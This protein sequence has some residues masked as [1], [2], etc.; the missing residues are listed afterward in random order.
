VKFIPE[1]DRDFAFTAHNFVSYLKREPQAYKVT[2]EE[3]AE[4]AKAVQTYREALAKLLQARVSCSQSPILTMRKDSARKEAERHVSTLAN[5]IR[6]RPDVSD[7]N[8]KLLRIK[9]RASKLGKRK[10]PKSPPR[11]EFL[12]SGDGV[13]GNIAQGSGSGVHVLRFLD[14]NET[15]AIMA[16][17]D[18]GKV[19]RRKPD[20]AVRVELYFDMVP[21]GDPRGVPNMPYERGWP[22]YLRSFTRSPMEVEFPIPSQPML[23]VYWA[24]WADSTGEVSRWSKPCVARLEGWTSSASALPP[25]EADSAQ[26][27]A[28]KVVFIQPPY[29]L[30]H[31]PRELIDEAPALLEA[32]MKML[33]AA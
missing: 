19:R 2:A 6:A 29:E 16:S 7:S 8:K 32:R 28:T 25:G 13:R 12:G 1:A 30:A 15:V 14:Y 33:T 11:L 31:Q 26:C 17:S 18:V 4:I 5:M 22:K 9:P 20:G 27:A 21:A 24:R 23:I 3:L 10:C